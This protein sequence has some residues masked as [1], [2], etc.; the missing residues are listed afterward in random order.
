MKILIITQDEPFYLY[1]YLNKLIRDLATKHEIVGCVVLSTSSDGKRTRLSKRV[2]DTIEV[3]GWEFFFYYAIRFCIRKFFF[4]KTITRALQQNRVAE[5]TIPFPINHTLSLNV[6]KECK[7]ELMISIQSN[8]IFRREFLDICPCINL[9]TAPLP[10]Y[11]GLMPTFWALANCEKVTAVS[12]F[13]VN[14]GIDSGPIIVQ[15]PIPI[16]EGNLESLIMKSKDVGVEA[17]CQAVDLIETGDFELTE[18][19]NS[20]ATYFGFPDKAAVAC[21]KKS[22]A[23]F[24]KWFK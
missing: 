17:I 22:G 23:K 6:I 18:N 2:F 14:E 10:K 9:H 1:E 4:K 13:F 5:V 20:E 12:V 15:K 3:F 11:R 21:F 16:V 19:N 8:Q 24:F 7:P